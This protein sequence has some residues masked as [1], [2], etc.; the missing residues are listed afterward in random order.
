M[1]KCVKLVD[2]NG[3]ITRFAPQA[4]LP[5]SA[6]TDGL[7]GPLRHESIL[8]DEFVSRDSE[9]EFLPIVTGGLKSEV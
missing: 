2:I 8:I 5:F 7:L 4:S 3:E 6:K 1:A 9:W